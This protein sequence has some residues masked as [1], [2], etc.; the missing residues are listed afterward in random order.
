[1]HAQEMETTEQ[2]PSFKFASR[3]DYERELVQLARDGDD[4]AYESLA[5]EYVRFCDAETDAE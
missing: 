2:G 3:K 1:M 4:D 5:E